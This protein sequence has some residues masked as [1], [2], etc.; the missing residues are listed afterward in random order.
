[1]AS[2]ATVAA[3][4]GAASDGQLVQ[5]HLDGCREAFEVLYRRYFRRL[6]W[7]LSDR[8]SGTAD[9]E[10]LAQETLLR[11]L[12]NADRFDTSAPMWP[13]LKTIAMR[14]AIDNANRKSSGEL[15]CSFDGDDQQPEPVEDRDLVLLVEADADLVAA[16]RQLTGRHQVALRLRY[17]E[18]W[19]R[20]DAAAFLDL[21]LNAFDQLVHRASARIRR[22]YEKLV[23]GRGVLGLLP[24]GGLLDRWRRAVVRVRSRFAHIEI[25]VANGAA[26]PDAVASAFVAMVIAVA[27]TT[28]VAAAIDHLDP[29]PGFN[30]IATSQSAEVEA[31]RQS[32]SSTSHVL[33]SPTPN[34]VTRPAPA[35]RTRERNYSLDN[36]G[37]A[38]ETLLPAAEVSAQRDDDAA[39]LNA[40]IEKRLGS[41]TPVTN[42]VVTIYCDRTRT[43]RLL[44]NAWDFAD[45]HIPEP[46]LDA[47]AG[48]GTATWSE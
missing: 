31:I 13:W 25:G 43:G 38:A 20:E 4:L 19:S 33:A 44:C 35:A 5:E 29:A 9:A 2:T 36:S 18:G 26:T 47:D 17:L 10:D 27:S 42:L 1:M 23:D 3:P 48:G 39:T 6:V 30:V 45:Q 15:P 41:S 22:E 12:R 32:N 8:T 7:F 40:R 24:L 34:P 37:T 28:V 16:F 14:L 21:N 11:A 46:T